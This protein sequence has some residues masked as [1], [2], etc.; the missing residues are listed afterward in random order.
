MPS[1][2]GREG[3]RITL[4]EL[5]N[6]A[7]PDVSLGQ[8]AVAAGTAGTKIY[9]NV[10]NVTEHSP[11]LLETRGSIMLQGWFYLGVAGLA[12]AVMAWAICEPAFIDGEG[13]RWGNV[14][15]LPTI[16]AMLCI[17]FGISE[18]LVERSLKKA[19]YRTLLALPLGIAFGFIFDIVA[20]IAYQV[21]LGIVFSLGAHDHYNPGVWIARGVG[22]VVFG[23]AGGLVYGII[24]QSAKK[25]HYGILGGMLGAGL[26]GVIFDPISIGLKGAVVSRMVGFALFGIATGAAMG[27]V[28]S[29]LKDKWLYVTSGPLAGKQFILYKES[30]T[31]GRDQQCDIYLFKD[32]SILSQHAVVESRGSRVQLRAIGPVYVSG[33]P[34]QARVLQDGDLVQIGR[35]GFRYKEKQKP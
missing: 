11:S 9:G 3:I 13:H 28:E 30:T 29:A 10:S 18:S 25:A 12:G 23:I 27:V 19:A 32:T 17:G 6:V 21:G 33:Q 26:G 7:T 22:W 35:Y 24:G 14:W 1:D 5:Q 31:I 15:M 8:T 2:N 34:V 16:V 4:E 20:N